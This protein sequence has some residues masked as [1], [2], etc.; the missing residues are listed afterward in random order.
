MK[1]NVD[2]E[3]SNRK[4]L[5]K[6]QFQEGILDQPAGSPNYKQSSRGKKQQ[7]PSVSSGE[8]SQQ[9]DYDYE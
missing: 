1:N 8:L 6:E 7:L 9:Q 2:E 4:S 5:K 3:T